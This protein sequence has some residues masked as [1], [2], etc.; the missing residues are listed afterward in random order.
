MPKFRQV[1]VW[2]DSGFAERPWDDDPDV[3]A[4]SR[5]SRG[6][7][8]AYSQALPGLALVA[9]ASIMRLNADPDASP[10]PRPALDAPLPDMVEVS[11]R[12]LGSQ[13]NGWVAVPVGFAK[14]PTDR[15]R[16][17][18]LRIV[19]HGVLE[20]AQALSWDPVVLTGALHHVEARGL[21]YWSEGPWKSAPD[22][23]HRARAVAS[24][25]DDGLGHVHVEVVTA[26][27]E[28]IIRSEPFDAA[29]H[30]DDLVRA[31]K[32]LRWDGPARVSMDPSG[33]TWTDQHRQTVI[34]LNG[35]H[36]GV[37]HNAPR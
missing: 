11:A 35:G 32:T 24:I 8:E 12:F 4:F 5:V 2:P 23:R 1:H 26:A 31:C 10:R 36:A 21:R 37:P 14:L 27:G 16:Q 28:L 34:D 30:G 18:S 17:L 29:Y 13:E 6:I 20:L 3:D 9:R 7:C 25:S 33:F 22:R 19:H 15:A